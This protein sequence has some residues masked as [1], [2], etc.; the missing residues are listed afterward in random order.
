MEPREDTRPSWATPCVCGHWLA[1]HV[2]PRELPGGVLVGHREDAAECHVCGCETF[3]AAKT[4]E[5]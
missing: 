5:E 2:R 4:A 3:R 1:D